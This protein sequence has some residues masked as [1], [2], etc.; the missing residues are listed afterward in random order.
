MASSEGMALQDLVSSL[1]GTR[2]YN[3]LEVECG[4]AISA[5]R[6]WQFASGREIKVFPEP[7]TIE[8][9]S[10]TLNVKTSIVLLAIGRSLGM[11]INENESRLEAMLPP[12]INQLDDNQLSAAL[13]ILRELVRFSSHT[14]DDDVAPKVVGS[15][16]KPEPVTKTTTRR[17]TAKTTTRTTRAKAVK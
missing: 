2:S 13:S 11:S 9:I 1:K 3:E 17:V 5:Q 14:E 6:W 12:G 4:G 7:E 10:K 8:A 15:K 16:T